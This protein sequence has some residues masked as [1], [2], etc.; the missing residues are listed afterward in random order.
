VIPRFLLLVSSLLGLLLVRG[1]LPGDDQP[2]PVAARQGWDLYQPENLVAWCIVPFDARKRNPEERAVMVQELGLQRVA[3]DWR[4]EHV[5]TFEEEILAYQRHGIEFFAFWS[6]HPEFAPLVKQHGIHPQ[7]WIMIPNVEAD[8]DAARTRL[9]AEQLF[10][11]VR[12]AAELGCKVGLYN[13]GGW[14]GEPA[15]LVAVC[16]ELRDTHQAD[17]VGIVYNFHHGHGHIANFKESFALMQP[18]LLCVN[19]NGMNDAEMPKILR[20]GDG[21]HE[22]EMLRIVAESGYDGAIGIIDHRPETDSA[23]TL[24]ENLTGLAEIAER[25]R[26]E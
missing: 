13:H 1:S 8:T 16:E 26:G 11:I 9:A 18:H 10:P 19:I 6:W 4:D 17:N 14:G 7:F 3:Y 2:A 24:R 12:N 21:A 25:E 20:V 23:D 5:P 15:N 22:A